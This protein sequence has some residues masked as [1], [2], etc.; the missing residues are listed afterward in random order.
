MGKG[1]KQGQ[2]RA[3]AAAPSSPAPSKKG[4]LATAIVSAFIG[5]GSIALGV[6]MHR[7]GPV[8]VPEEIELD[9]V[10]DHVPP[11]ACEDESEH[12]AAWAAAGECSRN[13]SYMHA[14]CRAACALCGGGGG[15]TPV[16]AGATACNDKH[17]L[18]ATW[19]SIGECDT[20]PGFMHA[21]CRL[22]CHF[23]QSEACRDTGDTCGERARNH[24][25][26]SDPAMLRE[27]AWT[28]G[29]CDLT[30]S[31]ACTRDAN[32]EPA[33]VPGSLA[34]MFERVVDTVEGV[35][36]HSR[37]P[38][39]ITLDG[40]LSPEEADGL[41]QA[42]GK[43]WSRSLAGDGVQVA[44]TSSTSWCHGECVR[45]TVVSRV[46]ERMDRVTGIPAEHA[47]FLQMLRYEPGQ[48]YKRHHDQNSPR[49]SPWG[50]RLLTFYL[51]LSDVADGG[52]TSFPA[53]NITVEPKIGRAILWTNVLIDDPWTRDDRTDHEALSVGEGAVKFGAN[54]WL[55]MFP[56]RAISKLGC[57]NLQYAGNFK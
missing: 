22:S 17:R 5:V 30:N 49:S 33:A 37:D 43:A 47:E 34:H 8:A 12:C 3:A 27:C 54:A 7:A 1:W 35:V 18:C 16:Q 32:A 38:W 24:G 57:D 14:A 45:D 55:H 13:P 40:F 42:G 2:K 46:Q 56:Y 25:C 26:Y 44:R 29:A 11:P 9:R 50:P 4:T 6:H 48:Y 53:L 41:L 51:Y 28:C 36:V 19:A 10:A 39:V 15:G 31:T 23:C 21:E 20:N 52:Q